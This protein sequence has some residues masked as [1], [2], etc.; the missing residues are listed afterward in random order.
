[1][2]SLRFTTWNMNGTSNVAKFRALARSTDVA[3]LNEVGSNLSELQREPRYLRRVGELPSRGVALVAWGV[4]AETWEPATPPGRHGCGATLSMEWVWWACGPVPLRPS[5]RLR[6]VRAPT[7]T[8]F[9]DLLT[10]R[11]CILAGDFNV[12]APGSSRYAAAIFDR[13]DELG[14]RSAYHSFTGEPYGPRHSRRTT[15]SARRPSLHI[16]FVFLPD[17]LVPA[18]WTWRS[19]RSELARTA[20]SP[21]AIAPLTVWLDTEGIAA[22]LP[23]HSGGRRSG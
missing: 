17:A 2:P 7:I 3:V 22:A 5:S 10:S 21:S 11:P 8:A 18:S 1:M 23:S 14:Y 12:S 6:R 20:P 9:E 19:D 15:I 4:D 16:D 13:L